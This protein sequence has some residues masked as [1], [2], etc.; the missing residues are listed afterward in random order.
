MVRYALEP[1]LAGMPF[2]MD[3]VDVDSEKWAALARTA[4]PPLRWVYARE[5]RLLARFEAAATRKS[6]V[7]YVVNEREASSLRRLAGASASIE[8]LQNGVDLEYLAPPVNP[9]SSCDVVFCG[10]MNYAPNVQG[11]MWL[12][13]EV[14]PRVRAARPEARLLLVGAGPTRRLLDLPR[15]DSSI[16]VTGAVPDVRPYLWNGA[17]AAAPLLVARGVQNKVLEAVGAGLPAV[18]TPVVAGGLP[19]EIMAACRVAGSSEAF[20]QALLDLLA[21]GPEQRRGIAVGADLQRLAW[22]PR[23]ETLVRTL[24][25]IQRA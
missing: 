15:A 16:V 18:V 21:L 12:A 13:R 19:V 17:V 14:W 20:S 10:V 3:M 7:T 2:V 1:P 9:A 6:L 24:E 11:A 22:G 23:L 4:R 5:A 25:E 8:V